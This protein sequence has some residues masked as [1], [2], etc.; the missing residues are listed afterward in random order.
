MHKAP[1]TNPFLKAIFYGMPGSTKTR[2]AASS[3]LDP[4]TQPTLM[5]D[6][7]GN[8]ASVRTY[9]PLPDVLTIDTLTDFNA[10]YTWLKNGQKTDA[11][12]V[13]AFDLKPPY[14]T[15]VIDTITDVQ[16]LAFNL[17][18]GT[19]AEPGTVPVA[20]ERNHFNQVLGHMVN[21]ARL[22]F[23][24]EMN[25]IMTAQERVDKNEETGAQL[26]APF[27]WGQ[28]MVEVTSYALMVARLVH[29]ARTNKS[30]ILK[31]LEGAT[32]VTDP[33]DI[34]AVAMFQ[35]TGTY[36][37]KDQYDA[38][39]MY[40]ADPTVSKIMDAIDKRVAAN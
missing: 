14:K 22:Y 39:G 20:T 29:R 7:G 32:E 38:C 37:A 2:T 40:M 21:F 30:T 33:K 35:P 36:V 28:S 25:V 18:T 23:S 4:R 27:I 3:A 8:P 17:A 26:A 6:I 24:L 1:L 31:A 13:K 19:K 11:Q 10:V 34:V 15:I 5:L 16:R 12:I 9:K